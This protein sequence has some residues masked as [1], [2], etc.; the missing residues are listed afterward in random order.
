MYDARIRLLFRQLSGQGLSV[1][2]ISRGLGISRQTAYAWRRSESRGEGV[3][4]GVGY[5]PRRETGSML[6]PYK[7]WIGDRL[8]EFPKLSAIRL[9]AEIREAGYAGGYDQVRRHVREVRP[10]AEPERVVR[11]ETP[12]GHQGQVDFAEFRLPW[13][14]RYA[15]LVVLGYSR[16][17]WF[18]FYRRQ[19]MEV[20]MRGLEAAFGYFGGVPR[21]LLFDQLKSVIVE[22]RRASGGELLRNAEFG[23]FA[24]H[25]G[26]RV[27]ACRPYRARTKGKVERP[28]RYVRE[29]FFYGRDFVS[30]EDLNDQAHRWLEGVANVRVHGTL[31]EV[32]AV[33]FEGERGVLGPLADRS[34]R[35]VVASPKSLG[36]LE[37]SGAAAG[38]PVRV[39]R[40]DL[41]EYGRFSERV[42]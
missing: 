33:R 13:G 26:F 3:A 4:A 2:A 40:R 11:F 35:G 8:S 24:Q 5:G 17:L 9:Y 12:P 10:R 1:T 19:T 42:S 34:Y 18:R 7:E 38:A 23:R 39:E 30:D 20:L 36:A 16:L 31:G 25:W 29:G 22:D 32:P 6:D 37:E 21:E 15:L 28:V 41:E 14:K 27:R